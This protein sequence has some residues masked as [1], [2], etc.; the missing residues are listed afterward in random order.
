MAETTELA[1]AVADLDDGYLKIL[2]T[3]AIR[4]AQ[5]DEPRRASFWHAVA[6]TLAEEQERR[7]ATAKFDRSV[8][9]IKPDEVPI[10]GPGG[11]PDLQSMLAE[12]RHEMATVEAELRE[13]AG[14]LSA[15]EADSVPVG[16]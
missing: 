15:V 13:S 10:A 16:P 4:R 6:A 1:S 3:L 14:D 8:K 7:Q 9:A 2:L 11:A 12:L 5:S